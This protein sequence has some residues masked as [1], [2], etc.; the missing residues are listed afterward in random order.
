MV[1]H[2]T[3][4]KLFYLPQI[5]SLSSK[6]FPQSP[7]PSQ[8]HCLEMHLSAEQANWFHEQDESR[9][10]TSHC[11]FLGSKQHCAPC[12]LSK[13]TL[14][15][16]ISTLVL[17]ACSVVAYKMKIMTNLNASKPDGGNTLNKCYYGDLLGNGYKTQFRQTSLFKETVLISD[18]RFKY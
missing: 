1:W 2:D 9:N 8:V 15:T 3:E 4:L 7:S 12:S 14:S 17:S 18:N 11:V 5:A 16:E 13:E 6:P 10:D